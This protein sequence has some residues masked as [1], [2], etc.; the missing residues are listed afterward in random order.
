M[1]EL[2]LNGVEMLKGRGLIQKQPGRTT[3][4]RNSRVILIVL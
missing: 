2:D 3:R 1:I 4:M